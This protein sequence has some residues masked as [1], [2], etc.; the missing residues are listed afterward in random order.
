MDESTVGTVA[1]VDKPKRGRKPP[2]DGY[3]SPSALEFCLIYN[4]ASSNQDALAKFEAAKF[5]MSYGSLLARVNGYTDPTRKGGAIKLK[6]MPAGQRGR[7]IDATAIN[8]AIEAA[9]NAATVVA[10]ADAEK[11]PA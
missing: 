6:D 3:K 10:A 7:K 1:V 2:R 4:Q 5:E 9:A 8:A 11:A